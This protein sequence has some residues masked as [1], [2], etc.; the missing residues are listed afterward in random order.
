MSG[1]TYKIIN[2]V[3]IL[4]ASAAVIGLGYS[5][6]KIIT[7]RQETAAFEKELDGLQEMRDENLP[8]AAVDPG[9]DVN[10]EDVNG[11]GYLDVYESFYL[12][13]PDFTG[14]LTIEGT[15][16]DFPVMQ[17][18][19]EDPTYYLSHNFDREYSVFGLPFV[20]AECTVDS[21]Q[22][23]I[24]GHHMRQYNMFAQLDPYVEQDFYD[25]HR[26]I[27]F[28]T[29]TE[30]REYE[31]FAVITISAFDESFAWW[32]YPDGYDGFVAD[33]LERSLIDNGGMEVSDDDEFITLVTCEYTHN[34]GRLLIIG[35]RV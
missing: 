28:D 6:Y 30:H 24:Y 1:K 22:V 11:D 18:S 29:R 26:I 33:A 15:D 19:Q 10:A 23:I 5:S 8:T 16:V 13:N 7:A 20:Q 21:K 25:E 27:N 4:I 14:W 2:G 9:D 32:Q 35:K 31:V 34:N 3:L 12:S 17:A